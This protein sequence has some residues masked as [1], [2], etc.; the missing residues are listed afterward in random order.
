MASPPD[1]P[2]RAFRI[3][4]TKYPPFDGSGTHRWG[5]RWISPGRWV[6]HAGDSY[7][8]AVLENLVHWQ[9]SSLPPGLVCVP[10]EIPEDLAYE[11]VAATDIEPWPQTNDSQ[12]RAIGDDWYE[13]RETGV[14]WVPSVVSAFD[15]N[16]LFNQ[17]H[18]DFSRLVVHDPIPA[19]IDPR[20]W[21]PHHRA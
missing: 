5:S 10:V 13:R 14:L 12:T 7:A 6:V 11:S 8:L 21:Q 4:S 16:V 15:R 17:R 19:S 2:R 9:A 18:P 1:V 3:V 20:L